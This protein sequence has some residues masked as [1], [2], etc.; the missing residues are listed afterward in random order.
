MIRIN[1]YYTHEKKK[2]AE[3]S[4]SKI[5]SWEYKMY[6]RVVLSCEETAC[7]VIDTDVS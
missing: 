2:S 1:T 4:G 3:H 6:W 7:V 5:N